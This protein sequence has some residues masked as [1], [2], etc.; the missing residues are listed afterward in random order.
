MSRTQ[1]IAK[2]LF[3][4]LAALYLVASAAR[5]VLI[6]RV[7]RM[8]VEFPDDW[9]FVERSFLWR[10]PQDVMI[11]DTATVPMARSLRWISG[12]E[13]LQTIS[14]LRIEPDFFSELGIQK[15][16]RTITIVSV[17][18]DDQLASFDVFPHLRSLELVDSPFTCEKLPLLK[19]LEDLQIV[20]PLSKEGLA[21]VAR[22]TKL[23]QLL[24]YDARLDKEDIA[25]LL[26]SLPSLESFEAD[27]CQSMTESECQALEVAYPDLDIWLEFVEGSSLEEWQSK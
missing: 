15:R 10:P 9:S 22:L 8:G 18:D 14:G 2:I 23:K 21:R 4:A 11:L 16:V 26:S 7:E 5:E 19:E 1:S 20:G 25:K 17:I 24:I 27:E 13:E 12:F 3:I 6:R